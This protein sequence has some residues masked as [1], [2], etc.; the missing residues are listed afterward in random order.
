MKLND[1]LAQKIAQRIQGLYGSQASAAAANMAKQIVKQFGEAAI[2]VRMDC[3]EVPT[4]NVKPS[5]CPRTL[6][7]APRPCLQD[8]DLRSLVDQL[9]GMQQ[10]PAFSRMPA[11]PVGAKPTSR[12]GPGKP[13][14]SA[15]SQASARRGKPVAPAAVQPKNFSVMKSCAQIQQEQISGTKQPKFPAPIHVNLKAQRE[16]I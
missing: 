5:N 13:G 6:L 3:L 16:D 15:R 4:F 1:Q 11:K 14:Y 7:Y 12:N 8:S 2:S 9:G 10:V